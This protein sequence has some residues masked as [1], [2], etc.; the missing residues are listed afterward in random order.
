MNDFITLPAE[1]DPAQTLDCG[2]AFRWKVTDGCWQGS[3]KGRVL[4]LK[5][6]GNLLNVYCSQEEFDAIWRDYFDM[7]TD[8][9]KIREELSKISPI[10]K[11]AADFAPGIHILRQEPWE[12]LCSFI[13]SQN[14][15]IPRIQGIIERLCRLFG[16]RINGSDYFTFPSAKLMST[17]TVEDLAPLRAG[18]RAKYLIDAAK[19]VTSGE[20]NLKKI[21][22][23]P[24]EFGRAELQKIVGVGPKVAE[25]TLLY[26]FH[27]TECFPI[28][29]WMK[30][31]MA[32]LF[33]EQTPESFGKNAGIAQQYIFHY[34]RMHPEMFE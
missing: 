6:D 30:R 4:R 28:D 23:E 27:K 21:A 9:G 20:V 5:R 15:N 26:G 2:Q 16:E 1:F 19:K 33:P 18:F 8:Y 31:A 25:C 17:L 32:Q 24:V 12:A 22:E 7:D 29:V 34:S 10:M 14:N 11:D 13:I 3:A